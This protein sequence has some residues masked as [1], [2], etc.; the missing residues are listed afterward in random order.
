M[1]GFVKFMVNGAG[2]A[3]RIIA[4]I[5]LILCGFLLFNTP[6]WIMIII[7]L[8]PLSAGIFDFCLLAPL[9]GYYFSGAKTREAVSH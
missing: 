5:A 6:N 1:K 3:L 8:I 7:G 2:R 9:F 4:G